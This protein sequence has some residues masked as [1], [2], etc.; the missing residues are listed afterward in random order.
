[1][2]RQESPAN[3]PLKPASSPPDGSLPED[4]VDEKKQIGGVGDFLTILIVGAVLIAAVGYT[5]IVSTLKVLLGLSFVIFIHEFG[6]FAVAKLCDVHVTHFSIGF[7]PVIPGCSFKW[8]ETKYQICLLPL[9]G[10]VQMVGQV[11]GDESSDGS[12]SDPR[13]Y[14]NKSVGQRMAII[15]AGVIMNVI[16]ALICFIAIYRGPG[17]DQAAAIIAATDSDGPAFVSGVR[18]GMRIDQIGDVKNPYFDDLR[19]EV[20][21]S[22]AGE[23]IKLVAALPG[24]SKPLDISI[25][26]RKTKDD[27]NPVLGV[28]PAQSTRMPERREVNKSLTTPAYLNTPAAK[29][30][31]AFD[32]GDVIIGTSDPKNPMN[33]IPLPPDPFKKDQL[34]YFEFAR[35]MQLLAGQEATVRVRRTDGE[36]TKEVD[37]IVPPA[38]R[39]AI[40]ATMKMGQIIALRKDS[41]AEKAKIQLPELSGKNFAIRGDLIE[42]V[43]VPDPADVKSK[44]IVF[45]KE[46]LDP[47]RLPVQLKKWAQQLVNAGLMKADVKVTLH[48]RRHRQGGGEEFEPVKVVLDWDNSWAF[49]RAEPFSMSSPVAIPELGLAYQVK[50]EV[51]YVTDKASPLKPGDTI[52]NVRVTYKDADGK[53]KPGAWP[54]TDLGADEWAR[55]SYLYLQSSQKPEKIEFKVKRDNEVVEVAVEPVTDKETP[56]SDRGIILLPDLRKQR[57]DNTL[58]AIGLGL[59]GTKRS[60]INVLNGIRQMISGRLAWDKHLGGP[61]SIARIAY[62]FAGQDLWEFIYFLGMIS[63]NLAVINFL[64]I[65]LLDGGHMV[66]LIYEKLRGKPASEGVRVAATYV[67]LAFIASLILLVSWLDIG[68]LLG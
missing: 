50:S 2:E 7:G 45:E 43:E 64:P 32:F 13:S 18:T 68:R 23:K 31:P 21:G 61:I 15:S 27:A 10:Y 28:Q 4:P 26:P 62:S 30:S 67:G 51:A 36:T 20:M 46:T 33:V 57:T 3:G 6:H 34:D 9:G 17:K 48:V 16:L 44:T 14:R 47:E 54:K 25:E 5:D 63:V 1:L 59:Q 11:D 39:A 58:E 42:K 56:I 22:Y 12:E 66:F 38:Y 24:D 49:D 60:M 29:A 65:P 40:G 8:G 37:V 52:K 35:R 55:V 53:E 19:Y 41:P